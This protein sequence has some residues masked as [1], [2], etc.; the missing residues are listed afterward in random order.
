MTCYCSG[1][2]PMG[3]YTTILGDVTVVK[4]L[5]VQAHAFSKSAK[6]VIEANG[7]IC[8]LLSYP[9]NRP[10]DELPPKIRGGGRDWKNWVPRVKDEITL[11]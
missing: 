3:S 6:E 1:S 7:G 4:G 11:A 10:V 8:Q 9:S 5:T 2:F